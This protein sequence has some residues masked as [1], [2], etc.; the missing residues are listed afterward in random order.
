[1]SSPPGHQTTI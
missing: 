1:M